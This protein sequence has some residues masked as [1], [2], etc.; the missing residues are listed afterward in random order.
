V[1]KVMVLGAGREPRNGVQASNT[2]CTHSCDG[3]V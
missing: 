2:L 3:S 1:E